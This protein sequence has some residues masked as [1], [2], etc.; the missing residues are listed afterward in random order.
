[1]SNPPQPPGRLDAK[2]SVRPSPEM[3]GLKSAAPV[4]TTEPRLTGASH[5]SLTSLRV[6]T[7][8]SVVELPFTSR[9]EPGRL[10]LKNSQCP[11]RER[12][13]TFSVNGELTVGPRLLGAPHGA[14]RDARC[15]T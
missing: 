3:W 4:L 5:A 11:S 14:S 8:I 12:L 9:V 10:L 2:Y 13:T 1:M 7:Q 6:A 15:A